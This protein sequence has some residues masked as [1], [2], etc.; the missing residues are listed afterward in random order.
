MKV[1]PLVGSREIVEQMQFPYPVA[2]IVRA[3]HEKWDGSGYPFGL[4]G[5]NIPIGAR[6]LTVGDWLDA[7]ISDREYRKGIPIDETMELIVAETGKSFD[8]RVV[9]IL[10][11]QYQAREQCAKA[12]ATQGPVLSTEIQVDKGAAPDPGLDVC[13]LPQGVHGEDF[14]TTI[15]TA[16]REEQ[17][18]RE[19]AAAGSSLDPARDHGAHRDGAARQNPLRGAG[20][21]CAARQRAEGGG[22]HRRE[23]P[24][25]V[26]PG[27]ASG[28]RT[29][30]MGGAAPSAGGEWKPGR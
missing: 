16:A 24:L 26:E 27:G 8:P 28:R 2:P 6:I 4:K 7:M 13:G 11:Q 14:L 25:F 1:H 12:Q 17:L 10:R 19:T 21:F 3:H 22:C 9:E 5:G 29:D 15:T 30:G 18:L 23:R 20:V